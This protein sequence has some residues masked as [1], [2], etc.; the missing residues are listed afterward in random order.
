MTCKQSSMAAADRWLHMST[1]RLRSSL[2]K[3][4]NSS[5]NRRSGEALK[6]AGGI[7]V[8]EELGKL[9]PSQQL[10]DFYREKV[11]KIEAQ[12]QHLLELLEKYKRASRPAFE[13]AE[14]LDMTREL[15][16]LRSALSDINIF[17]H[18]ERQQVARL[19]AENERLQP[20]G[21]L[22]AVL[23]DLVH[24][25]SVLPWGLQQ[26]TFLHNVLAIL[27]GEKKV[28]MMMSLSG[29]T[30]GELKV[31]LRDARRTTLVKQRLPAHLRALHTKLREDLPCPPPGQPGGAGGAEDG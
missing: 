18:A 13:E 25:S 15:I 20:S 27:E 9:Q 3:R 26:T 11:T 14:R 22:C 2:K 5:V 10:L 8:D 23:F 24:T 4:N 21:H 16:E 30:E 28:S 29:L 6:N 19:H 12:H 17:L 31:F 1:N 7:N